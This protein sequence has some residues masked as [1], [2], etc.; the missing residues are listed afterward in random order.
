MNVQPAHG[1]RESDA[2]IGGFLENITPISAGDCSARNL[3]GSKT[4]SVEWEGLVEKKWGR[5]VI[6]TAKMM[7][8]AEIKMNPTAAICLVSFDSTRLR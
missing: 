8:E 1:I 3:P 4:S 7:D 2:I 5:Q 6:P